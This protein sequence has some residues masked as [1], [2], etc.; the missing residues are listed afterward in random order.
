MAAAARLFLQWD[1]TACRCSLTGQQPPQVLVIEVQFHRRAPQGCTASPAD[2]AVGAVNR[3]RRVL[4]A[5][6]LPLHERDR[7]A[8]E[9]QKFPEQASVS[10][11]SAMSSLAFVAL[12]GKPWGC[13]LGTCQLHGHSSPPL[14]RSADG[15]VAILQPSFPQPSTSTSESS[16]ALCQRWPR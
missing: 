2:C 7:A 12:A 13:L 16:Q 8:N 1:H 10:C 14:C 15:C 9:L 11:R 4:A 6:S 5:F 3:S